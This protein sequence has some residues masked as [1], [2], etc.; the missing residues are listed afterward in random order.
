LQPLDK[1]SQALAN[2]VKANAEYRAYRRTIDQKFAESE[3]VSNQ[4]Y[5]DENKWARAFVRF[6]QQEFERFKREM[7][8][9]ALSETQ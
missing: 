2:K 4:K 1:E 7:T 5:R 6:H 3:R 8:A 9:I